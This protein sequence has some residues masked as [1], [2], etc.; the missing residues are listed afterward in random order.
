MSEHA[1][2]QTVQ[3]PAPQA[4]APNSFQ[5]QRKCACG[6]Y[7][8]G[9][10]CDKCR[11]GS[12][13]LYRSACSPR[14]AASVPPIVH[15]VLNSPGQP[16]DAGIRAW[17]E[18]RFHHDFSNVRVH[19]DQKAAESA[20]AVNAFA[21]TIGRDV[22][23][24]G[25]R[26]EPRTEIGARLLAHELTHVVQ[27]DNRNVA[28]TQTAKAIS[29]PGDAAEVEADSVAARVMSGEVINITQPPSATLH[30]LS[31][32][33]TAGLVG[34][35]VGGLGAIAT[36]LWLVGAFDKEHFSDTELTQYLTALATTRR[37]QGGTESD[38]K[39]RDVVRRWTS[40]N[41]AFNIDNGFSTAR[42]SLTG[43]ELKRL[44]IEQMLDGW[45]SGADE[46][47]IITILRRSADRDQI[48]NAIGRARI[49]DN[50]SG[51]NRRIVE[52]ITLKDNDFSDQT[53]VDRLRALPADD[54]T[55][56]RDNAIDP[57]VR[58]RIERLLQLQRITTPLD[59]NTPVDPQGNAHPVVAG[60]DVTILPDTTSQAEEDRNKANTRVDIEGTPAIPQIVDEQ[61][62]TVN[63][64]TVPGNIQVTIQTI[65]G[66]GAE[67]SSPSSYGRGTTQED[68]AAGR[69]GIGFHEGNHGLDYLEFLRANPAPQFRGQLGTTTAEWQRAKDQFRQDF[70]AYY[71]RARRFSAQRT[72]CVG[73]P[74]PP[75][76][77]QLHYNDANICTHVGG[78][79]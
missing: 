36:T 12:K 26:Y 2:V 49:W 58:A 19:T 76:I 55:D 10:E 33:E 35:I 48:V 40:G 66:P 22:V 25:G 6:S 5:L 50:F 65:Y 79:H 68:I 61:G 56:Y 29:H 8:S 1:P 7:G 16:L 67:R 78:G 45:T 73:T 31:T 75:D 28:A 21:Y 77:A 43:L 46:T 3:A 64:T 41:A 15:E 14:T 17:M 57:A 4:P 34:G 62:G 74:I 60:F 42:G 70:N 54:L 38:N 53:L 52:A 24:D 44:L 18:P 63:A 32:G 71:Q 30:A 13:G 23:F 47:A 9:G 20:Q 39:A 72:E 51:Q 59:I 11:N 27:Q 37:I 69:T